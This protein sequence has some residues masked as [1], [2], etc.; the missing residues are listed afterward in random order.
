MKKSIRI[1]LLLFI[2]LILFIGCDNETSPAVMPAV[3]PMPSV[4]NTPV[5]TPAFTPA[6]APNTLYPA[7]MVDDTLSKWSRDELPKVEVSEQDY[8]GIITS[9]V[10]LSEWPSENGQSNWCEIDSP[11]AKYDDGIIVLKDGKLELFKVNP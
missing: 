4:V 11:Y 5:S 2:C 3:T 6:P 8:L 9:T 7:I 1:N 10:P